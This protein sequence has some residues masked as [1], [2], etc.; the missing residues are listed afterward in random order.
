MLA[1]SIPGGGRNR[2]PLLVT[3]NFGRGRT[4]VSRPPARGAGRCSSRIED[5]T[6]EIFW[7]QMMR[8]LVTGSHGPVTLTTSTSTLSDQSKIKLRA[9]VRDKTYSP[10]LD[11]Q[12]EAH[13]IA[14]D[15]ASQSV[16]MRPDASEPGVYTAEWSA[17]AQ[18]S[19]LAEVVARRGKEELGRAVAPFRREDGM[20][21]SFHTEQN[22]ELLE[23]LA[24]ETG[25][26]YYR[27]ADASRIGTDITF[28]NAGISVRETLDLWNM[29][30][31]FLLALLLRSGEWMLR[32]RWGVI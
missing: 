9:E 6:H 12:V 32:R 11:S 13:V 22:R 16:A 4:A 10:A 18:G 27:P 21:E 24:A 15:G 1:E 14:P 25:G 20:A 28:S 26:R 2:F 31:L 8:W 17:P 30:V 5:K 3:Q 29:P 19:Y 23:K 7:Q